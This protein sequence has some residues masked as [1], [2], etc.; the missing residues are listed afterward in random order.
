MHTSSSEINKHV[1]NTIDLMKRIAKI[2]KEF[3]LNIIKCLYYKI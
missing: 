1:K 3:D 2:G